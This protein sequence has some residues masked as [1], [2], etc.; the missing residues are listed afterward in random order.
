MNDVLTIVKLQSR[1]KGEKAS[2]E[3]MKVLIY[4]IFIKICFSF[5]YFFFVYIYLYTTRC[6]CYMLIVCQQFIQVMVYAHT[7]A[8]EA[9]ILKFWTSP[10]S[11]A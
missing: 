10:V 2:F 3:F 5:I 8:F 4:R 7:N 6:Y 11:S 9:K 1:L